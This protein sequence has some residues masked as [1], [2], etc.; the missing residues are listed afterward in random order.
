VCLPNEPSDRQVEEFLSEFELR[1]PRLL[2]GS[3][4]PGAPWLRVAAAAV[5]AISCAGSSWLLSRG[6]RADRDRTPAAQ[7]GPPLRDGRPSS[8]ALTRLAL[9]DP[10]RMDAELAEASRRSLPSFRRPDS[11][12]PAKD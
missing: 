9:E 3:V 8:F 4:R 1:R 6:L 11:A 7:A 10:A 12:V 5:V 2:P